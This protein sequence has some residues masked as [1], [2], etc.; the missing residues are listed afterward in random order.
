MISPDTPF[1]CNGTVTQWRYKSSHHVNHFKALV[2]RPLSDTKFKLIGFND[3]PCANAS[4][5][6]EVYDVPEGKRIA[7]QDGDVIG[8]SLPKYLD[9]PGYARGYAPL[10]YNNV[11]E[12]IF[13]FNYFTTGAW[14]YK[15]L[16]VNETFYLYNTQYAHKWERK[17]SIIGTAGIQYHFTGDLSGV[18]RTCVTQD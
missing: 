7:V 18:I 2:F 15:L 17:Y 1:S 11:S 8:W 12:R 4:D 9:S 5:V 10:Q 3:I 13:E 6:K 16:H 14:L